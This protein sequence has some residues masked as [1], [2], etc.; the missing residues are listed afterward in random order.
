M[1]KKEYAD[2]LLSGLKRAT[3]RL[4]I[5][6]VKYPE[7]IVH[8]GGRPVAKVR[9]TGRVVKRVKDL[10]DEDA[11]L[12]GFRDKEELIRELERVYGRVHPG[13][14]VT[15]IGL[16]VVKRFDETVSENPYGGLS[17][18]DLARIALRY[19]GDHFSEEEKEILLDLTR[20]NSIRLS[21]IRL[22]GGIHKRKRIRRVLRK[23]LYLL[24]REG[25]L[26]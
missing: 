2:K 9:V 1:L 3:I 24:Q 15:I 8:A 20:T 16:E 26:S 23:A 25:I 7:L 4:G 10:T 12:D 11:R 22:Y 21:A 13:D 18:G 6:H 19:I 14:Y 5:V 17:P